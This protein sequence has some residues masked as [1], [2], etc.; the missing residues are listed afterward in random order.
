MFDANLI[1]LKLDEI[2]AALELIHLRFSEVN[3]VD[4]LAGTYEGQKI[5]DA[6]SM[7]IIG[8]GENLKAI[9]KIGGAGYLDRYPSLDWRAIKGARDVLAHGYFSIDPEA[10]Y[11]ICDRDVKPLLATVRQMLSDLRKG[12]E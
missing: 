1:V 8:I 2:R 12:T 10:I 3:S 6:I 5:L 11:S 4:M 7:Q 9:D